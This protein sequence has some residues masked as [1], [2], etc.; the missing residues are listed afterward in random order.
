MTVGPLALALGSSNQGVVAL[1]P[2]DIARGE[3]RVAPH[4][5][6]DD[7]RDAAALHYQLIWWQRALALAKI[8]LKGFL[9]P[10]AR[11]ADFVFLVESV[12]NARVDA[13]HV[14]RRRSHAESAQHGVAAQ[15]GAYNPHANTPYAQVVLAADVSRGRRASCEAQ[16]TLGHVVANRALFILY[17][18]IVYG[19]NGALLF[20]HGGAKRLKPNSAGSIRGI[21]TPCGLLPFR[22]SDALARRHQFIAVAPRARHPYIGAHVR[23]GKCRLRHCPGSGAID[24]L[25]RHNHTH[26]PPV[27]QNHFFCNKVIYLLGHAPCLLGI[28]LECVHAS[29][30]HRRDRDCGHVSDQ[31]F[32]KNFKLPFA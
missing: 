2:F 23:L 21:E 19:E 14:E 29:V 15:V 32:F 11:L 7:H 4:Q 30:R 31:V 10:V 3:V 25:R 13:R 9:H 17:I 18:R 12:F 6:L 16:Q 20:L 24:D 28:V 27:G 26:R 8:K 1:G 5:I 22:R